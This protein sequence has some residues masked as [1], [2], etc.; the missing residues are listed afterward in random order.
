M[1]GWEK[2]SSGNTPWRPSPV[3]TPP[4]HSPSGVLVIVTSVPS[5]NVMEVTLVPS[6]ADD[7]V[8]PTS[9]LRMAAEAV[10]T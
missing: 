9:A 1:T 2:N 4:V 6:A 7:A 8:R 10:S 5:A 3:V